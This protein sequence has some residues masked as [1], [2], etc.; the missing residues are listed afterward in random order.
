M[1]IELEPI[2]NNVGSCKEFKYEFSPEDCAEIAKAKVKGSVK[3]QTG[4]V[5]LTAKVSFL[6]D[7]LCDRCAA[8]VKKENTV[9]VEH[10]LVSQLND[11]DNDNFFLLES[12]H[13]NLDELIREDILLSL[14]T[15]ILCREDCK[16]LCPYC[17]TN[18]NEKQCGCKKPVDPRLEAL[19]QFLE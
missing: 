8:Q 7:T 10:I 18:L 15:K 16:G 3:N 19:K 14:P 6:I 9:E 2:F 5:S 17:G 13:F 4:I 1:F 12:M 11:T